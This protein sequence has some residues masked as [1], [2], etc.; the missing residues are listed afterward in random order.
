MQAVGQANHWTVTDQ[1]ERA[2]IGWETTATGYWFWAE[3]ASTCPRTGTSRNDLMKAIHLLSL[4]E[5]VIVRHLTKAGKSLMLDQGGVTCTWLRT[6]YDGSG[7]LDADGCDGGVDV[8]GH[9][10]EGLAD[11]YAFAG[12]RLAE[13]LAE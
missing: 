2:K 4:E 7:A 9:G 11:A 6:S 12:G 13:Q 3:V 5:Y 1:A 10:A 8:Y